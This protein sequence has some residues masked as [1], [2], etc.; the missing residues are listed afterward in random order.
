MNLKHMIR[1]AGLPD[2][3]KH[4]DVDWIL[5]LSSLE[6][7]KKLPVWFQ[8]MSWPWIGPLT[9]A[10]I[11]GASFPSRTLLNACKSRKNEF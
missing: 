11:E 3:C 4:S 9:G 2:L 10:I 8:K 6:L 1:A 5:K 7:D